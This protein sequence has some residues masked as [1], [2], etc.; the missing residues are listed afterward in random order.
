MS[1]ALMK[2]GALALLA[3]LIVLSAR[4]RRESR[5]LHYTPNYPDRLEE[6]VDTHIQ[7]HVPLDGETCSEPEG[8][9]A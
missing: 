2:V 1:S 6:A 4:S 7:R 5:G 3:E 9:T 8:G